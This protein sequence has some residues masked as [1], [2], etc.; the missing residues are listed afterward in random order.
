MSIKSSENG[1]SIFIKATDYELFQ[2]TG[3]N[4]LNLN[5]KIS[6]PFSLD[7]EDSYFENSRSEVTYTI[8]YVDYENTYDKA[9]EILTTESNSSM[10]HAQ[11][12]ISNIQTIFKQNTGD[13]YSDL[14]NKLMYQ[15][16]VDYLSSFSY[17][18][19][20]M[21]NYMTMVQY[22]DT[23][24][25]MYMCQFLRNNYKEH[26]TIEDKYKQNIVP[27]LTKMMDAFIYSYESIISQF[28]ELLTLKVV[29]FPE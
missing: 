6:I 26:L 8:L 25:L 23:Q 27:D 10:E 5:D 19:L 15:S 11:S 17:S 24:K 7:R 18:M 12:V 29:A 20:G 28:E 4:V 1:A 14:S 3:Y 13:T 22:F 2:T 21:T 16:P 9:I